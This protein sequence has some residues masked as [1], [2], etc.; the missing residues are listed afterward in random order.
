MS[1]YFDADGNYMLTPALSARITKCTRLWSGLNT[2]NF[3]DRPLF[4][5]LRAP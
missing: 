3:F 4:D 5:R 2:A 1:P